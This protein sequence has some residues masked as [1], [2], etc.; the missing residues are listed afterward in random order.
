MQGGES[1]HIRQAHFTAW[2]DKDIPPDV[3]SIIE[4]RQKV[5]SLHKDKDS[6]M[7]VHCR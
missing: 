6:P 3:T 1:F 2:P 5:M 4:F 7:I